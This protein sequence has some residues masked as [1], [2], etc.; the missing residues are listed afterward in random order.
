MMDEREALHIIRLIAAGYDPYT[1]DPFADESASTNLP[2][3]NP[4]TIR[5]LC[6]SM[7]AMA[8]VATAKMSIEMTKQTEEGFSEMMS[9]DEAARFK[10]KETLIMALE[11]NHYNK[12]ETAKSLGL[13]LRQ[14]RYRIQKY[15]ID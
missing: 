13:S 8:K 2:E 14:L 11:Q 1:K 7:A 12:T 5:A 4:A 9:L 15:G 3:N 10:E 6:V